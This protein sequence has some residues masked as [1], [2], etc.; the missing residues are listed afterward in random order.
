M[1][2]SGL[3]FSA[4]II[5]CKGIELAVVGMQLGEVVS[6]AIVFAENWE[7]LAALYV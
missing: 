7:L 6:L 3:L 2:S 4:I 5:S 1:V